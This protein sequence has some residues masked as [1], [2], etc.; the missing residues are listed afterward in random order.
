[1]ANNSCAAAD[2]VHDFSKHSAYVVHIENNQGSSAVH[3]GL[4]Q[5]SFGVFLTE[6][7]KPVRVLTIL[8][9]KHL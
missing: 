5:K 7:F 4:A 3:L 9:S 8:W 1:M 2:D 6:K